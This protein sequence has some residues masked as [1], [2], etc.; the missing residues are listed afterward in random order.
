MAAN[1]EDLLNWFGSSFPVRCYIFGCDSERGGFIELVRFILSGSLLYCRIWQRTWRVYRIGSVHPFRFAVIFSDM[2]ANV[3]DLSNWFGSFS[4]VR[5]CIV[6]CDSERGGFI[7]LV[8]FILS[9]SL[10]YCRIW[11]RTW[12]IYRIGLVRC[13]IRTVSISK[14]G[15]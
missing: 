7:E 2:T 6:G 3:E 5:C 9:G 15:V 12:R 4:L 1:V 11:Q 13:H 10:L 14:L 8:R